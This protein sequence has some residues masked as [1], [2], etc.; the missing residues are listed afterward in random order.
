MISPLAPIQA[1]A[2]PVPAEAV[3][4]A[5]VPD[6]AQQVTAA[7][8]ALN[9]NTATAGKSQPGT[10]GQAMDPLEKALK[11]VNSNLQAWST[12]MRFDIDPDSKRIVVSI[13]DNATGTVLRTVPSDAVIRVA[14]M[15]SQLQGTGIDTK[16]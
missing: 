4:P 10:N 3:R 9:S 2:S 1:Q 5:T 15:I 11:L 16:A 13:I 8:D 12:G 6:P 7:Q 14:K